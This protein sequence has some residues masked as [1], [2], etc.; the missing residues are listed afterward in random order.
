MRNR[1][2]DTERL[3]K[4]I[5]YMR[6][7]AGLSQMDL[8]KALGKSVGTIKNWENGLGAPDFPALLEWF[9]RCGADVEKCLMAIY[10][11]DKY[12]RIYHPKKDNE[13]LS[14]LQE[15]L[16]HEDAAYLKRLYYNVFYDTGSDWHAQL[17]MLTA[18]NKLPLADRI[19]SA[20]AYLDNFLIRQARGEVKDAFIEPDLKHLK[21]SIQQAKQS[22]CERKDSYLNFKQ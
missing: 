8:A 14:A 9:D 2:A 5:I 3:I 19:T 20:Q 12:E 7:N 10:D 18:L 6:K 11:P 1:V 21:E 16:K 22:V 17:D 13:T 4:V 15:Y